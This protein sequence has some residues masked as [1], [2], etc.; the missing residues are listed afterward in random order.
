VFLAK[1]LEILNEYEAEKTGLLSSLNGR[2]ELSAQQ[3]YS[4]ADDIPQMRD[5]AKTVVSLS[6]EIA[7]K[8][9]K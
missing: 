9:A 3:Y 6:E 2:E 5:I 1:A 7:R 8:K 4:F